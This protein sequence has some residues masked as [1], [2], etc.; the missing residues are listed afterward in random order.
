MLEFKLPD[1]GEGTVEGEIV[2]WIANVGD[3][4]EADQPVVE[5]MTDK[6][7]VELTAPRA[8][9][10]VEV[11]AKAGDVVSVGAVIYVLD[12][13]GSAGS[14]QSVPA[15]RAAAAGGG[16]R[17]SAPSATATLADVSRWRHRRRAGWR[18]SWVSTSDRSLAAAPQGESPPTTSSR[19]RRVAARLRRAR[20]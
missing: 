1:I 10:V 15:T 11:R 7:T 13:G 19:P 18:A 9:K 5:V 2:R 20:P 17:S 4:V 3:T 8:G 12:D 14:T 6:A 16:A